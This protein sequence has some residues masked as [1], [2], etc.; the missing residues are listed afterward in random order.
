MALKR[1]AW[2]DWEREELI[3]AIGDFRRLDAAAFAAKYDK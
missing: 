1:I 3:A 2:W